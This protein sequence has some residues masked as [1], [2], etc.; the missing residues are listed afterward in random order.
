[1]SM[2]GVAEAAGEIGVSPRR[3]RQMIVDGALDGQRV[4]R[5]WVIDA[6]QVQL[7]KRRRPVAG[8]P[9]SAGSA[10]A[11]LALAG[12]EDPQLSPVERSRAKKRLAQGLDAI[13]RRLEARAVECWFYAHPGVLARLVV[14]SELV[15]S[16][17][18]AVGSHGVDLVVRDAAEG[19]V[20]SRDVEELVRRFGLDPDADRPN[21]L[22]RVVEDGFWPF[23]AKQRVAGRAVV[24]VDLL[25]SADPR[26][27]RAGAEL[28]AQL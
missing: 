22:M 17:V 7:A 1:M 12:G 3:V 8:R 18:S 5:V 2:M 25:G 28:M 13:E 16:G 19:Y 14:A 10:W 24:A 9:W 23:E 27:R 20:R 26:S 11:V 15:C 21:F 4:G 6:D